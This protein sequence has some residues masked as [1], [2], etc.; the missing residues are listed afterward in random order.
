MK[1][2]QNRP[3][4]YKHSFC[5]HRA[6]LRWQVPCRRARKW[7]WAANT[8]PVED[9]VIATTGN[10]M[11]PHFVKLIT[12]EAELRGAP[13]PNTINFDNE[14]ELIAD[15]LR[16]FLAAFDFRKNGIFAHKAD[17]KM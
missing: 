12:D 9:P 6:R 17:L 14:L 15:R 16:I 3:E 4:L 13:N 7:D 10:D 5:D 1:D 8:I 11:T 2:R